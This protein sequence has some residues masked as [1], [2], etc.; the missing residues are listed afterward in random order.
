MPASK[1]EQESGRTKVAYKL[2][3][4][5]EALNGKPAYICLCTLNQGLDWLQIVQAPQ[6][7][8]RWYVLESTQQSPGGLHLQYHGTSQAAAY[9]EHYMIIPSP[10]Q[11][12][13]M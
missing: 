6:A 10:S 8:Q 7:A 1:N 2:C 9:T 12:V 5:G 13:F 4:Q 11:A 3:Q